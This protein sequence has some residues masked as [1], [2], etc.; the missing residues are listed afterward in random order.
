MHLLLGRYCLV[1]LEVLRFIM[2]LDRKSFFF[3][4]VMVS[5][6]LP[7]LGLTYTLC[8]AYDRIDRRNF[9]QRVVI[10]KMHGQQ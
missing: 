4:I 5:M 1:A 9:T 6:V 7:R 3:G 2:M 8:M 10:C